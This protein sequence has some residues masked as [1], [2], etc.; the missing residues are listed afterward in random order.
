MQK[1][2]SSTGAN[3]IPLGKRGGEKEIPITQE[4]IRSHRAVRQLSDY[5]KWEVNQLIKTGVLAPEE[6]P[7]YDPETGMIGTFEETEEDQ[8]RDEAESAGG[9]EENPESAGHDGD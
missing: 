7:D 3:N 9:S 2:I 4:A 8:E 1:R 6:H 5:E